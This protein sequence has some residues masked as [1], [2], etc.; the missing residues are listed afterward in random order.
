M[1]SKQQVEVLLKVK[2]KEKSNY[3]LR[4]TTSSN[5]LTLIV[6]EKMKAFVW[7]RNAIKPTY[8]QQRDKLIIHE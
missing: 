2:S 5:T 8:K 3:C 1:S 4:A 6:W 7:L